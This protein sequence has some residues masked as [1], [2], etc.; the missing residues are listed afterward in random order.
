MVPSKPFVVLN[1]TWCLVNSIDFKWLE[2]NV[3]AEVMAER[4]NTPFSESIFSISINSRLV[5]V[6]E[7]GFN[8]DDDIDD[9]EMFDV[10]TS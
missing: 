3:A 4:E 10:K 1:F 7:D 8:V 5:D 2:G 9:D 6:C